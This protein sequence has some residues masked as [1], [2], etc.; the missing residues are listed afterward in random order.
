[1]ISKIVYLLR[2][3]VISP[4]FLLILITLSS[5]VFLRDLW[6]LLDEILVGKEN[7]LEIV[8]KIPFA[9]FVFTIYTS[10]KIYFPD[11]K[12]NSVLAKWDG[13]A[14]LHLTVLIGFFYGLFFVIVGIIGMAIRSE[15]PN[16]LCSLL[17]F[18][19]NLGSLIVAASFLF[20]SQSI[21]IRL[22]EDS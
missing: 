6:G 4:E 13:Y 16:G 17:L 3:L 14:R 22:L 12:T 5:F 10:Y 2:K 7:L 8:D 15:K 1:M 9:L 18:L 21:R 11:E 20:A 19:S